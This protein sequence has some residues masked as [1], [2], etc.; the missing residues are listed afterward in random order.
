LPV[1]VL[2]MPGA[3]SGVVNVTP[4]LGGTLGPAVLVSVF[5][6]AGRVVAGQ[7]VTAA[8]AAFVLRAD[9]AFIAVALFVAAIDVVLA[10]VI[11]TPCLL[12]PPPGRDRA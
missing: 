1:F 5:G 9:Q 11:S 10:V 7:S 4:Q 12:L 8:R 6:S 2:R 3:A